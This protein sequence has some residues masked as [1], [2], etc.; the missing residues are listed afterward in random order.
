MTRR[1]GELSYV[2]VDG[3]LKVGVFALYSTSRRLGCFSPIW[4]DRSVV[5]A[6]SLCCREWSGVDVQFVALVY[7]PVSSF[8]AFEYGFADPFPVSYVLFCANGVGV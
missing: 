8:D 6:V 5:A 7:Y 1:G 3:F 4:G 2:C